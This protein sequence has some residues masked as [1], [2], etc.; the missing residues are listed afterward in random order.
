MKRNE[1]IHNE[2]LDLSK[3]LSLLPFVN[4]YLVPDGYFDSFS[5]DVISAIKADT[6]L[7]L[8]SEDEIRGLSPLLADLRGKQTYVIENEFFAPNANKYFADKEVHTSRV[9]SLSGRRRFI[10]QLLIAASLVG[11]IGI[12]VTLFRLN[13]SEEVLPLGLSIQTDNQFNDQL[14]KLETEDIVYYLEQYELSSDRTEMETLID[15]NTL[16]DEV[17]YFEEKIVDDWFKS[18]K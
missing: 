9:V 18:D 11:I 16:P 14:A 4:P 8:S 13:Q 3:K 5:K 7:S 6:S 17:E 2:L 1:E 10:A 12:G 15:P